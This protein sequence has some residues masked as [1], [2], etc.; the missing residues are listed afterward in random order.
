MIG[1]NVYRTG[2]AIIRSRPFW[3][4]QAGLALAAGSHALIEFSGLH[5][6]PSSFWEELAKITAFFYILPVAY[7]AL[8]FGLGG[9]LV[10]GIEALTLTL[11][12]IIL[13]HPGDWEWLAEGATVVLVVAAGL[14]IGAMSLRHRVAQMAG[15]VA[16]HRLALLN[17]VADN[18]ARPGDQRG[19]VDTV[20]A[21]I[22]DSLTVGAAGFMP[23]VQLAQLT[24]LHL[25]G[26][27]DS[28][29]RLRGAATDL[30]ADQG[31][32]V[33]VVP[34]NGNQGHLGDLM[35]AVDSSAEPLR[36]DLGVMETIADSMAVALEYAELQASERDRLRRYA[37]TLTTAQEEERR[38]VAREL[39]DD[40]AQSL[41]AL[42]RR[43]RAAAAAAGPSDPGSARLANLVELA[44][45]IRESVRRTIT[46]LR[47]PTLD[48]LGL[49]AAI[50]SL[51]VGA[52][53]RNGV[54]VV[55][56]IAGP[57][58]RLDEDLQV[59]VYR[60]AQ[61]AVRNAILHSKAERVTVGMRSDM[62]RL[63]LEIVDDGD[64]FE[65]D[66]GRPGFGITGMH[67][68]AEL[69][70]GSLEIRSEFYS[71]TTVTLTLPLD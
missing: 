10:V 38:R 17:E 18:L 21:G 3:I 53:G 62:G 39:H 42:E 5:L 20:L 66:R 30:P 9:G 4:S 34:V 49:E 33:L 45:T 44:G 65:Q 28:A 29:E 51:A 67:E 15:E 32:D 48:D 13:R 68:R 27:P 70:G 54:A 71:G 14:V 11:P 50:K 35:L 43:A 40:V 59:A 63:L 37:R 25:A 69:I 12:S 26:D 36:I 16:E 58:V 56:E 6:G 2:L 55:H 19:F 7:A 64:G 31:A 57:E 46:G 41:I 1:R 61:E 8:S 23:R 24:D 52:N 47:P 60:I 22:S